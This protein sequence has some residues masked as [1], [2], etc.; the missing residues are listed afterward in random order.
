MKNIHIVLQNTLCFL[1]LKKKLRIVLLSVFLKTLTIQSN[2]NTA[3]E[4]RA[5]KI[6][7]SGNGRRKVQSNFLVYWVKTKT[8]FF[9]TYSKCK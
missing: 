3:A 9:K 6:L 8:F 7:P 5:K 4:I 1:I 2:A